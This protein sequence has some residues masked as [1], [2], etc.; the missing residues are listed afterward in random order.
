MSR[1]LRVAPLILNERGN[2]LTST[3]KS[4]TSKADPPDRGPH[5]T[6]ARRPHVPCCFGPHLWNHLHIEDPCGFQWRDVDAATPE[7]PQDL[8]N[9]RSRVLS[10]PST[11][12]TLYE[13]LLGMQAHLMQ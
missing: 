12:A 5:R 10:P 8:H 2:I 7:F 4:T 1:V 3:E 6:Q 13:N 11:K 9:T